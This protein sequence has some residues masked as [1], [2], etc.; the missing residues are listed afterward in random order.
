MYIDAMR[1]G[2]QMPADVFAPEVEEEERERYF[3]ARHLPVNAIPLQLCPVLIDTGTRRIL[4]D[5]GMG[6]PPEVHPTR[7]GSRGHS[8]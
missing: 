7:D 2:Q 6:P 1:T 5:S 4:V 8:R 3:A